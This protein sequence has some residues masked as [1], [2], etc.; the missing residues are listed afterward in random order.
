MKRDELVLVKL[1][2]VELLGELLCVELL[3]VL[4]LET[5]MELGFKIFVFV[6]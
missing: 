1:C 3:L 6:Y 4:F 2:K 5:L